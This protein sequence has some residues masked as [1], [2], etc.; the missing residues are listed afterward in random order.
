MTETLNP[1]DYSELAQIFF[2]LT[3]N[4]PYI[5]TIDEGKL[6]LTEYASTS[7]TTPDDKLRRCV[8]AI[9]VLLDKYSDFI[10]VYSL[11]RLKDVCQ[12]YWNGVVPHLF[13]F[14][15]LSNYRKYFIEHLEAF[16]DM[17][18]CLFSAEL[19]IKD[20]PDVK[21]KLTRL[22]SWEHFEVEDLLM[23]FDLYD[24]DTLNLLIDTFR[25]LGEEEGNKDKY[26]IK[27]FIQ[28]MERILYIQYFV[29]RFEGT[30]WFH[31]EEKKVDTNMTLL[32]TSTQSHLETREIYIP[33]DL[34]DFVFAVVYEME[35]RRRDELLYGL[36]SAATNKA[37]LIKTIDAYL[38]LDFKY[39]GRLTDK[40]LRNRFSRDITLSMYLSFDNERLM[41]FKDIIM[42]ELIVFS[43]K[44]R[45]NVGALKS[46]LTVLRANDGE[47]ERVERVVKCP[48]MDTT[49]IMDGV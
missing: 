25:H 30:D 12:R 21:L 48:D 42:K 3:M 46:I 10:N 9:C 37:E 31:F 6:S 16:S 20:V 32:S 35:N 47:R 18:G 7:I 28:G 11:A 36:V 19:T 22:N 39:K 17:D 26:L 5:F 34:I 23:N 43:K 1:D 4:Y 14:K 8:D 44:I 33:P 24:A 41:T 29:F 13:R 27:R 49:D 45:Q 15:N 40:F 38:K 2:D